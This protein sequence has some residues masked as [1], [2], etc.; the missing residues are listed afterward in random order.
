MHTHT[1]ELTQHAHAGT[2]STTG[3]SSADGASS[4]VQG[5]GTLMSAVPAPGRTSCCRDVCTGA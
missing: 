5:I 1:E 2:T 4:A 3:V